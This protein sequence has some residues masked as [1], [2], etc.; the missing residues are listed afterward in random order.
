MA[1]LADCASSEHKMNY[2]NKSSQPNAMRTIACLL[3]TDEILSA[4]LARL[5]E[6]IE[7]Q[8]VEEEAK[9]FASD[10]EYLAAAEVRH[11]QKF[12]TAV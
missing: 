2:I 12:Q 1:S 7:L 6:D 10:A 3:N 5:N 4:E 11:G 8:R 9:P